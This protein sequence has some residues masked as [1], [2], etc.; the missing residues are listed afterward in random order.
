MYKMAQRRPAG[1]I[2]RSIRKQLDAQRQ[3]K[4]FPLW[5]RMGRQHH[6]NIFASY[7][8]ENLKKPHGKSGIEYMAWL[9]DWYAKNS[10]EARVL[11]FPDRRWYCRRFPHLRGCPCCTRIR[12]WHDVPFWS[13]FCQISDKTLLWFGSKRSG[14]QWN[15]LGKLDI[16]TLKFI[17]ESDVTIVATRYLHGCWAGKKI[18]YELTAGRNIP[19]SRGGHQERQLHGGVQKYESILLEE[20]G[21]RT[22]T[23]FAGLAL[24]NAT[25]RFWKGQKLIIKLLSAPIPSYPHSYLNYASLLLT[26]METVWGAWQTVWKCFLVVPTI[27]NRFVFTKHGVMEELRLNFTRSGLYILKGYI[28]LHWE[29]KKIKTTSKN[30]ERCRL[31]NWIVKTTP[32]GSHSIRADANKKF[33]LF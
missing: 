19:G 22:Y 9:A 26:D 30:I 7:D 2:T 15:H 3:R 12:K 27:E 28:P 24:Q 5:Y 32:G 23:E 10:S 1:N 21:K 13:Y 17:V 8:Q 11:V 6:G 33:F 25:G 31:K 16:H 20:P 29:M 18:M 14:A 4:I